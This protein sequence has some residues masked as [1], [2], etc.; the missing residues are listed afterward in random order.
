M[1]TYSSIHH[2]LHTYNLTKIT[3]KE[4]QKD[5]V[6][7]KKESLKLCLN[8]KRKWKERM[9]KEWNVLKMKGRWNDLVA[10]YEWKWKGKGKIDVYIVN[11]TNIHIYM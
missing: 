10:W 6:R 2:Q 7:Y 8:K 3:W 4:V 5:N 11:D 9:L 1:Q